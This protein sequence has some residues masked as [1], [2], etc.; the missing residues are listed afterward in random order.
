LTRPPY[1]KKMASTLCSTRRGEKRADFSQNTEPPF[2]LA[3][4]C[5]SQ[6]PKEHSKSKMRKGMERLYLFWNMGPP[7][8][9]STTLLRA[10]SASGLP[11][12]RPD[13]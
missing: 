5:K 3:G 9:V 11:A 10:A 1:R 4:L 6:R 12:T 2:P 8:H 7:S 13:E